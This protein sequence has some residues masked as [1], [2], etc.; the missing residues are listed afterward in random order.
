MLSTFWRMLRAD[1]KSNKLQFGLIWSVLVLSAMLLL[2]SLLMLNSTNDPWNRTFE[3]TNGPHLWVVSHQYDLDFTPLI[4]DPAV[5][6]TTGVMMA[7]AENPMVI[8]DEKYNIYLYGMDTPPPVAHPLLAAGRWLDPNTPDEVVLDF[9]L[10]NFYDIQV[11]DSITILAAEGEQDLTV[12]GFAVTAHWF[13]YNEVTKDVSPGVGYISQDTLSA[14]QPNPDYW[15]SVLGLRLNDPET[16]QE[17]SG[18]VFEEFPGKLRTVVDWKFIKENAALASTLNGMFM[19]LFSIMGLAAVGLIIFNT[20]GGQVLSQY[21]SIGL[22][23][24]IGFKPRQVTAIFLFEHLAIGFFASLVGIALGLAVA[25]Y[26]VNTLAENLNTTPP[27]IYAAAP[28]ILVVLLVELTVAI[29]TLIPAWQGGKIDTVQAITVGY[30]QHHHRTSK[31][32]QLASWLHMPTIIRMGIKDTF[33]RPLRTVLAIFSLLLTVLVAMTAIGSQTTI[34]F[35]ANNRVYFNG[36]SADMKVM[37]NFVPA[38]FVEDQILSEPQVIDYYEE[39]DL[40]GQ[41]PGF[42]EQPLAVRILRGAYQNFDFQI[43]E[44]RMISSPDEAVVGFAVLDLIGAAVGDTVEIQA[45]GHPL[46]LEIVGRN[47]ENYNMSNVVMI[48]SET[49]LEQVGIDIAPMSYN[50]KLADNSMAED[51]RKEWLEK[52]QGE[53]TVSVVTEEPL[54]SVLQLNSLIISLATILMVVAGANLMSTSLLSIRERVRDFGIQKAIGFTPN[55]IA[56]SVVVS[57]VTISIV[58]LLLGITLGLKLMAWFISQVGIQIGSGPDF[59]IIDWGGMS[60]LLPI[61]VLLAIFSSLLPAVRAA[62]L[63]VVDALRYE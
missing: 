61:L 12:V 23:K 14:I 35:L 54:A 21:R 48:S 11:G 24:A 15:Y 5:S 42:S 7:L 46:T 2:I 17:F 1:I 53:L 28:I 43:K 33:S 52:S 10:A 22:L 16:S 3:E 25:P 47:A 39:S 32:A 18:Q 29:A 60:L 6:Q 41:A 20:I 45:D 51:L 50:L 59:Y 31:L 4:E 27:N 38:E 44:G 36:T 8:G 34:N 30:R 55:Q 57:A 9:S 63:Q 56:I 26:L 37:R 62:R 40:W 19:G 49:Y 13:P 58:A